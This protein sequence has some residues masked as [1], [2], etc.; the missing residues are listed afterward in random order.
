MALAGGQ[1]Q[2]QV[3]VGVAHHLHMLVLQPLDVRGSHEAIDHELDQG[4]KVWVDDHASHQLPSTALAR[5]RVLGLHTACNDHL[6][7]LPHLA[8]HA[9]RCAPKLQIFPHIEVVSG[10][11][12]GTHARELRQ[13]GQQLGALGM[14]QHLAHQF[15][16][17]GHGGQ[18]QWGIALPH[19]L[20]EL[21]QQS[22]VHGADFMV[23][24]ERQHQLAQ[25]ILGVAVRDRG[26][27]TTF[28]L[29]S[30]LCHGC[31][32]AG[33]EAGVA[34]LGQALART[35]QAVLV[36]QLGERQRWGFLFC[37]GALARDLAVGVVAHPPEARGAQLVDH[38]LTGV[39]RDR[40]HAGGQGRGA[41][42][43]SGFCWRLRLAVWA[44]G[45]HTLSLDRSLRVSDQRAG[46][47]GTW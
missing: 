38:Q 5:Q 20:Q 16:V 29:C 36:E 17:G 25:S 32:C 46:L 22:V 10:L 14:Q 9:P 47:C 8:C 21:L 11:I 44:R 3:A 33:R 15:E 41:M 37:L 18:T 7:Q 6:A 28:E 24:E 12:S 31:A 2:A 35:Q 43:G 34:A 40:G 19:V 27:L 42:Q 4:C 13:L 39:A 30:L 26:D 23:C 45:F 1:A